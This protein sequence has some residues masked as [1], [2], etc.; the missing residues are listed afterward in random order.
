[1]SKEER[2]LEELLQIMR[3]LRGPEGCPWDREQTHETL[4][5]H[6]LEESYEAIDAIDKKDSAALCDELGD[7]LLQVVFHAQLAEEAGTFTMEDVIRGISKKMLH[8]HPHVF[9]NLADI[10]TADDVLGIWEILKSEEGEKDKPKGLMDIPRI[11]PGL[12][13]AQKIQEKA[14]R[15]GFDWPS[16]DGAWEKVTEELTEL[17]SAQ[18]QEE[19]KEEMGDVFFALVN[20]CRFLGINPEEALDGTNEKFRQ[21]FGYIDHIRQEKGLAWQDMSLTAMDKL[22]EDAKKF[23]NNF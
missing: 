11:L 14:A 22:W 2:A 12:L 16:V 13:R 18:N 9:G 4:K 8:R 5:R 6:L 3:T 19:Q 23:E 1:M 21:R 17:R 20:V 15:V 7:V 10:N